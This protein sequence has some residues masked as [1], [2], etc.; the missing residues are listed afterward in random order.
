MN[1]SRS[2]GPM[3]SRDDSDRI[4]LNNKTVEVKGPPSISNTSPSTLKLHH[5]DGR[6]NE[7]TSTHSQKTKS[8]YLNNKDST[9][10]L[11]PNA[12]IKADCSKR[13]RR[14][15]P[16]DKN[17][18]RCSKSRTE[19]PDL[20]VHH[21]QTLILFR[22]NPCSFNYYPCRRSRKAKHYG[23]SGE[24]NMISQVCRKDRSRLG[25]IGAKQI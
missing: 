24:P 17:P 2:K 25:R 8:R 12:L 9:T 20:R 10:S 23:I 19:T 11:A 5:Q 4:I 1:G 16:R 3:N 13:W 7:M 22:M 15:L 6:V 21:Y 14:G 18:G